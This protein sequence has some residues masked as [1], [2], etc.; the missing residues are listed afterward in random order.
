M[1]RRPI[2]LRTSRVRRNTCPYCG[3]ET[4]AAVGTATSPALGD[5]SI[6][7]ECAE[8]AIFGI[9]LA[10]RKPTKNEARRLAA[11]SLAQVFIRSVKELKR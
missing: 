8:P 9:G 10:L 5:H 6:C 4:D 11:N 1:S 7:L 3:F 2:V